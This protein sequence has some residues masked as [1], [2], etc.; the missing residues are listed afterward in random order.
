MAIKTIDV[1]SLAQLLEIDEAC[2]IDVREPFE[3]QE[4]HI[5]GVLNIP[6]ANI[7]TELSSVAIADDKILV[8]LCRRGIRSMNACNMLLNDGIARDVYNL[9]GGIISWQDAG[10]CLNP[11]ID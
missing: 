4:G 7:L 5:K 2:I 11:I 9:T 3:Y 6:L 1:H 8:L 10:Y